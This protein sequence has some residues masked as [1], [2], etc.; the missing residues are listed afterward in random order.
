MV[1]AGKLYKNI[2]FPINF[3]ILKNDAFKTS[4]SRVINTRSMVCQVQAY[5]Q[6]CKKEKYTRP[7]ACV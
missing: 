7:T 6:A 5:E 3:K 2:Y 4:M 1:I